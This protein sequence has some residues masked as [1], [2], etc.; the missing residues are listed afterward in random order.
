[1]DYIVV[2]NAVDAGKFDFEKVYAGNE[3]KKYNDCVLCVSRIEGRKSQLNLVKAVKGLPLKLILIGRPSPNHLKYFQ[4]V[5]NEAGSNVIFLDYIDHEKLPQ[6]YKAAK[7]HA[8]PSWFETTGLSS[9]EAGVMGC[10]LVITDKGDTEE[11]FKDF[12]YYCDPQSVESIKEA[13]IKAYENPVNPELKEHI[14]KNF[15]WEIT[16]EKTL[17]AY[18]K[19]LS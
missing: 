3:I 4:K 11:Y 8:L 15:N 6:Y 17:A 12:A 19:V 16:A 18:R 1:M 5:K 14:L 7:V 13:V 9:L 2:P 10:N